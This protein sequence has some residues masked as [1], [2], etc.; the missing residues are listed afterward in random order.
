M[1]ELR[2]LLRFTVRKNDVSPG[3]GSAG[4]SRHQ[5]VVG[6]SPV[7]ARVDSTPASRAAPARAEP[8]SPV[9]LLGLLG[10]R[11]MPSSIGISDKH[12]YMGPTYNER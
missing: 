3:P 5:K 11:R 1:L 2:E 12:Y 4:G 10:K 7:R 6:S 9:P 8:F